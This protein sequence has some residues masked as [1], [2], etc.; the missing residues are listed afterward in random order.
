MGRP[1]PYLKYS[2]ALMLALQLALASVVSV[3]AMPIWYFLL[4]TYA[5]G[6]T[7]N[8]ALMLAIHE[9]SHNLAFKS[10]MANRILGL[11]ANLPIGLPCASTFRRYH[12]EH[13][14]YQGEDGVDVDVPLWIEAWLFKSTLGKFIWCIL[15]PV[16]YSFRPMVLNPKK[17]G[18]WEA[19]NFATTLS[20]DAII[21]YTLGP[22]ALLYLVLGSLLGM[23]LHPVAGHFIAEH[24]VF[25]PGQETYSY[26]GWLNLLTFNVGYHN[27]HHDFPNI[28][29]S[30]LP[31]LKATA[32][33][34]YHHLPYYTSWTAVI[35]CFILNADIS[36]FC[37]VKRSLLSKEDKL[38][39]KNR[40]D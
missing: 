1:C 15:Q 20:S 21:Y 30:R 32:P 6:G 10:A 4:L 33:E 8:H 7:I 14:K 2:V 29:G 12:L 17:P 24:Y 23:G 39:L 36:G 31:Q 19:V 9:I 5:V 28:P 26:Y 34:F 38:E 27:E 11:V 22:R 40:D 13:H 35:A 18:V 3:Y 25:R 16:F 37:R